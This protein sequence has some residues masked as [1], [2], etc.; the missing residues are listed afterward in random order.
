M[1]KLLASALLA[2]LLLIGSGSPAWAGPVNWQELPA[3]DQGQ[4]WWDSG[5]LRNTKDG[6]ISVLS[7]FLPATKEGEKPRMGDLYVMEIDCG[8]QLYRDTSVNGLPQFGAQWL[9][10]AGD[11]LINGVIEASC[12]A[13]PA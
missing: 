1:A 11:S 7:R 6:Y 3:S 4:Q 10:A 12:A 8:Q 5:S 9:P 2:L 13:L